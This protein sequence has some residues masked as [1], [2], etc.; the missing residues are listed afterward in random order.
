MFQS[1]CYEVNIS[2]LRRQEPNSSEGH[3]V[4]FSRLVGC[5]CTFFGETSLSL[6]LSFF[7]GLSIFLL[8]SYRSSSYILE[9]APDQK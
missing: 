9:L 2:V 6:L 5:F 3:L 7:I 1:D 4:T 8:L